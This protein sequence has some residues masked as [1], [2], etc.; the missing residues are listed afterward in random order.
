LISTVLN[1]SAFSSEALQFSPDLPA[2]TASQIEGDL[3]FISSVQGSKVSPLHD[4]V[5]GKMQGSNYA[6]WFMNR[7]ALIDYTTGDDGTVAFVIPQIDSTRLFLTGNYVTANAPQIAR[8]MVIFHE[9]RHT[10][11]IGNYWPHA[12]CPSPFTNAMGADVKSIW[13]NLPLSGESACDT[14]V[15]GAYGVS[16]ILLQNIANNC[17]SCSEKV[18]LDANLYAQ[19]QLLRITDK[20][21]QTSLRVDL[22]L[23]P[24]N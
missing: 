10:E 19:D 9:A 20:E 3:K 22:G 2:V 23:P 11:S 1:P 24:L 16:I 8:L 14:Q 6:T 21:A 17:E 12:T 13:T 7:I 5:F 4:K 15:L 18:K